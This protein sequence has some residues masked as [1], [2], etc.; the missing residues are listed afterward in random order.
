MGAL[1]TQQQEEELRSCRESR[2]QGHGGGAR[3]TASSSAGEGPCGEM[4]NGTSSRAANSS[5]RPR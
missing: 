3:R 5:E 4:P 1:V 2:G